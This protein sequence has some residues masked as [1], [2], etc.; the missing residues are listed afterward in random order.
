MLIIYLLPMYTYILRM[1]KE[2][3]QSM[4]RHLEI[5]GLSFKAQY[6]AEFVSYTVHQTFITIGITLTMYF[7]GLFP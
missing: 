5:I 6:L 2:K 7:G 4:K 1:Q 3:Q